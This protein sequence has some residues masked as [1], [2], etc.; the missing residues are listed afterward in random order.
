MVDLPGRLVSFLLFFFF[1]GGDLVCFERAVLAFLSSE[2]SARAVL[3]TMMM[4]M[5]MSWV[6]RW[7]DARLLPITTL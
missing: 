5:L 7:F 4:L 3:M 2:K 6:L 1:F